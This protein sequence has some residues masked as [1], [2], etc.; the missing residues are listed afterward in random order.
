[1]PG[2]WSYRYCNYSIRRACIGIG[3]SFLKLC[4]KPVRKS[5]KHTQCRGFIFHSLHNCTRTWVFCR[6]FLSISCR[7]LRFALHYS[8]ALFHAALQYQEPWTVKWHHLENWA[9]C[10]VIFRFPE[11]ANL[12]IVV[13]REAYEPACSVLY[14]K[15]TV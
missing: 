2:G 8:H 15:N 5:G 14:G 3:N 12:T 10:P 4:S 7:L 9:N 6:C 13:D 1:M 11:V